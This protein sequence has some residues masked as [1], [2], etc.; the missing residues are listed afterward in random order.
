MD[1]RF[2]IFLFESPALEDRRG[3]MAGLL[4]QVLDVFWPANSHN[5]TEV[6]VLVM[7]KSDS[8]RLCGKLGLFLANEG[9]MLQ[10]VA[11]NGHAGL[12]TLLALQ[13]RV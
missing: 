13:Q 1:A 10:S 7:G 12:S 9:A 4:P 5:L 11:C 8:V 6:G 2:E 3:G